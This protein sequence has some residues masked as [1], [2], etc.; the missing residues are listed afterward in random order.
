MQSG[1]MTE[2][3]KSGSMTE[4]VQSGSM[5]CSWCCHLTSLSMSGRRVVA[6]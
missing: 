6:N 4:C 3:V 1:S 2:C 5:I